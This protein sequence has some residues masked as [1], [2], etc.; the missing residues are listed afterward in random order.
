M[1][2]ES[3]PARD[4]EDVRIVNVDGREIL[5][6]GTAHV[7]QSS[8][9]LVR[10]VI[11]EEAPDRVCVELDA[12]RHQALSEGQKWEDLDLRQLIR[13]KRLPAL[14]MNLML[15]SYQKRLGGQLGVP[16][17]TELLEATRAADAAGI[18][19]DLCDR[20]IRI[21]LRRAWQSMSF[22]Q[23]NQFLASALAGVFDDE[24]ISEED[25][26]ELRKQD[27]LSEMMKELAK[28]LPN[29][30]RVLIDERDAYLAEK[31]RQSQGQKIVAV[32]GAGHVNGMVERLEAGTVEELE[33]L[34]Q[35]PPS[36]S[37]VKII[38]WGVPAII[39][40]GL[41]WIAW[42]KGFA[43]AGDNIQ[44]W[45]LVNG[46]LSAIGA[47]LALASPWTILTAFIAA[48]ITS[49][50]PVIGAGYVTAF[51]Q[52][53]VCPPRVKD[54][55]TVSEDMGQLKRWWQN[56]LLKVFLAFLLPS[57]GSLA[58]TLLGGAEILKNA[59]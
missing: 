52:T 56:R 13:Q 30:K 24:T 25:L 23:K 2:I 50:I 43:Q 8:A 15:A 31:I 7:S 6:I 37:W 17:G 42:Q 10:R 46:T 44:Y 3:L 20:N 18:P 47:V 40:A 36:R 14:I 58:G 57:L 28:A 26:Q 29:L 9:D 38:G 1:S 22:W 34:D 45:V 59:F 19:Y 41:G 27:V 55:E 49:L 35:I 11:E 33:P 4:H 53:M 12:Q 16:P 39:L 5:I 54:F 32:V 51:V 21:T 48:P